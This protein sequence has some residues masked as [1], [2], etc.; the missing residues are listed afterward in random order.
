[1]DQAPAQSSTVESAASAFE[2]SGF[3][4]SILGNDTEIEAIDDGQEQEDDVELDDEVESEEESDEDTSEDV[5]ADDSE[6]ESESEESDSEEEQIEIESTNQLAEALGVSED[7][8]LDNL[9][10][11]VVINGQEQLVTLREAQGGYQKDAD[12]RQKTGELSKQRREFESKQTESAQ[13][14]EYQHHVASQVL[15]MAENELMRD[16][17]DIDSLRESDPMAWTVKRADL[18][19][20]KQQ[21]DTAKQQAHQAYMQNQGQI[22]QETQQ[23]KDLKMSQ[24]TEAL[25]KLMPDFKKVVPQ[26]NSYLADK[27]GFTND[28]LNAVDDHRL[29]DMARKAWLYDQQPTKAEAVKKKVKL[30]PKMVQKPSK[31]TSKTPATN[32]DRLSVATKNLK[33]SGHVRD[34]ASAI[35]QLL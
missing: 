21:L 14:V 27:Y 9:K 33:K 2:D 1:M 12:Y 16:Y 4:D 25:A 29:V 10:V 6:E 19:E 32:R 24:E 28:E 11:K 7:A 18:I 8:L 34:A 15:T 31:G 5:E 35:E 30:A 26:V 23:A 22:S 20:R 17:Q 13:Q 3:M